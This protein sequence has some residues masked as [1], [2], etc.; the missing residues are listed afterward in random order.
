MPHS[1]LETATFAQCAAQGQRVRPRETLPDRIPP[2]SL[3]LVPTGN[4]PVII[5]VNNEQ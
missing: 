3:P 4:V 2:L 5:R 1:M